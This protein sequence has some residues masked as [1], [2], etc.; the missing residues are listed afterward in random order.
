MNRG[1]TARLYLEKVASLRKACPGIS[2]TSDVIVGF[3]GEEDKDF[4]ATLDLL[5]E[6]RFDNLFSF[7]YS[8]REGTAAAA[9]DQTVCAKVK[10]ERLMILQS[11][12]AE[13]TLEKNLAFVGQ[14]VEVLVEGPSKKGSCEMTGRTR[15][16]RIVNFSGRRDLIGRM[17]SVRIS[18]A[19]LHSLYG[20]M[21]E[22]GAADV[23]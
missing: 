23:H 5:R 21:E 7:Q 11:L 16:N 15:G 20:I 12:Q 1:Y 19:F 4:Q 3:P 18:E 22:K 8:V 9:M 14:Q 6:V 2:I 17:V 10:R 13:H